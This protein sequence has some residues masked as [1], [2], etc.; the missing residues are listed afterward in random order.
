MTQENKRRRPPTVKDVALRAGVSWMTVSNVVNGKPSVRPT[1]REKVEAAISELGYRKSRAGQQLRSGRTN[2]LAL[3]VP[4]LRTPYFASLAHEI[5]DVAETRG[6][7]VLIAETKSNPERERHAARG[8]DTQLADG[9]ILRPDSLDS[10]RVLDSSEAMP[11][12]LLGE[13]TKEVELDH[14]TLDNTRSGKEATEHLLSLGRR[15]PLF[16]GAREDR[17]FGPGWHRFV[18]FRSA[19]A[20]AEL[21][22]RSEQLVD[23]VSYGRAGGAHVVEGILASGVEFDSLVC[24]TD[25]IA[26]GAMR[27]LRRGGRTVPDDVAVLGWDGILE[28][29]FSN[30]AL[31]TVAVDVSHVAR[32]AVEMVIRR[33]ENPNASPAVV[34]V[35][36]ELIIR[37][38]T[39]GV[40]P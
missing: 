7:T 11:L 26:V 17:Q 16:L 1:T 9:I 14:V 35:P 28:G 29:E 40:I 10:E 34:E 15:A 33:I 21:P 23:V 3:A 36:Q 6:Y 13:G 22:C 8:F 24:A 12:V 4:D 27:A 32:E 25:L 39:V 5:I 30:P 19:L 20:E 31:T 38:S 18:G 37:E 2:I